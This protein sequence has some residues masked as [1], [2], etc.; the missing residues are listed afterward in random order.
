M[1][2]NV[3]MPA[4]SPTMEQ[5]K[6]TQWLK[7]EGDV[8]KS[9]DPIAEI[10]TDKATMEVEAADDG[11]LAKILVAEGT[12]NVAVNTPIAVLIDEGE[13]LAD[14]AVPAP[15]AAVQI[16]QKQE[17]VTTDIQAP[18]APKMTTVADM[19]I[20]PGTEMVSTTVRDALRD[21]MAEEILAISD[22]TQE[23]EIRTERADGTVEIKKEDMLGHRKL[24]IDTRK[25]LMAKMKPKKY[26]DKIDMTSNGESLTVQLT[27]N[28]G[29]VPNEKKGLSPETE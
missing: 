23:G 13:S 22:E 5:G 26:G 25:W 14:V 10:E 6:L 3:L 4:L 20:P 17:E 15:K 7:K 28:I 27:P 16:V 12:D 21:A 24:R 18:S 29:Y 2:V 9:G 19:D 1:A 11:I 8:V